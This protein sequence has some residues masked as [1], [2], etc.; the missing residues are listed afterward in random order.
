MKDFLNYCEVF[1]FRHCELFCIFYLNWLKKPSLPRA[2]RFLEWALSHDPLESC[3]GAE[4]ASKRQ[5][6][7][8]PSGS[9]IKIV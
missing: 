7:S 6:L 4:E 9:K 2:L 1:T 8:V 3:G 5:A